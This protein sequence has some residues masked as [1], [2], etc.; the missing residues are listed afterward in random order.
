MHETERERRS[1]LIDDAVGA[2]C[3]LGGD[4]EAV[5]Q[6][7]VRARERDRECLANRMQRACNL[8]VDIVYL[9]CEHRS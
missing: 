9:N 1:R 5:L 7:K 3:E 4:D 6:R 2:G 8:F